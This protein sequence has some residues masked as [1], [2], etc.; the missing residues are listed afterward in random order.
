MTRIRSLLV[1]VPLLLTM[2]A[3]I[4][5]GG[6]QTPVTVTETTT[7]T[8]S[9]TDPATTGSTP[10][11]TGAPD[12][13][14]TAIGTI[15]GDGGSG[16]QRG[17]GRVPELPDQTLGITV[18]R[19]PS[20]NILCAI[21]SDGDPPPFAECD[22]QEADF[23]EKARPGDCDLAWQGR[24]V[25]VADGQPQVGRCAG[26]PSGAWVYNQEGQG[27]VLQYGQT[28]LVVDLACT[29]EKDGMVCWNVETRHG[30]QVSRGGLQL[31]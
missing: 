19:S 6:G 9:P 7:V 11:S 17:N 2:T 12:P 15:G 29:S 14:P 21:N 13:S 30:F 20:G 5:G 24:Y 1:A 18:F 23:P 16:G 28:T 22:I 8:T 31:F 3:C 26:D 27:Q 25:M 4:P 10:G